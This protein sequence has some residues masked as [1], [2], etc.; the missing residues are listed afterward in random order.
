M[1]KVEQAI[2]YAVD[3]H[4]GTFRDGTKIPYIL[5]PLE[6]A[7]IASA[8]SQDQDVIAAA[9]LHDVVEDTERSMAEIRRRFGERVAH[10][11]GCDTENKRPELPPE[12]TWQIRKQETIDEIPHLA[13]DELIVV[14]A[15][16][17]ANLRSIWNDYLTIGEA[18]WNRFSQPD[19]NAQ[20]WY[21]R[22]IC[23]ACGR[24]ADSPLYREYRWRL[25]EIERRVRERG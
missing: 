18:L 13:D 5:H 4:A 12:A 14:F 23:D 8:L 17:L 1:N 10:F 21:Y 25:D 19:P 11:V 22:G 24:L 6:A 3:A 16:K 20:L 15:D 9:V 7:A 2:L